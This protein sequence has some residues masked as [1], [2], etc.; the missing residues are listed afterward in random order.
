MEN[1]KVRK[2]DVSIAKKY[3]T[4]EELS[5]LNRIV[6]M[7]LD[8]A[9]NQARR[10]RPMYMSDWDERLDAFLEF[11]E[12]EILINLGKVKA[13]VAEQFANE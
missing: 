3:L 13:K 4:Q 10:Q 6:T 5:D 8:Y 12:H 11:N 7:Y 9:G 2:R 1:N